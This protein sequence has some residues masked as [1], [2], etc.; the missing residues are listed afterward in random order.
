MASRN[1]SANAHSAPYLAALAIG[2]TSSTCPGTA[3][4]FAVPTSTCTSGR[5]PPS[6]VASTAIAFAPVTA[7]SDLITEGRLAHSDSAAAAT[8]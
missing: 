8:A 5:L 1:S 3:F 2:C 7:T 4:V 6:I